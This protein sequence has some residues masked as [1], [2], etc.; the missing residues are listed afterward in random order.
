MI[1]IG[2]TGKNGFIGYHLHQILSLHKEEFCIIDFQREFFDKENNLDKFVSSCDVIIHL[3]A[4]N[5][6][7]DPEEIYHINTKLASQLVDSL[8]RTNS[9]AHLIVSSSIQEERGNHY[10][11]SKRNSRL[12]LSNWATKHGGRLSGLIIPNVFGPF[13]NPNYNSVIATFC[14]QISRGENPKIDNDGE[15]KLIYVSDLVQEIVKLIRDNDNSH[16]LII[17]HS[18]EIRVSKI[19]ELLR[20]FRLHYQDNGEIPKLLN[21]FEKNLFNTY[22]CYMDLENYFPRKFIKHTDNRG[23]FIEIARQGI[24]GQTSFST[25]NPGI[26][27]GNHFHTRKIE[28]FAVIKGKALIQLRR[29]GSTKVY[30]YYL[31][32]DNAA[33]VDIPIWY[34]HNI[35][36]IGDEKLYT[37]FWINEVFDASNPDTYFE[38]V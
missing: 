21:D 33:Y 30:Q 37:I 10:G 2:I 29:I 14:H 12:L 25:T 18:V 5:R 24:P 26:T 13:G 9:N 32:G 28:R 1:N 34:T 22:R 11:N 38:I 35:R 23:D 17:S 16:E 7:H 4:L 36:N 20:N 3:A 6:H 19:L 27:R 8:I 15:L 31:E